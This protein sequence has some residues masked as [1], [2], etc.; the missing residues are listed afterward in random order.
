MKVEIKIPT[1]GESVSEA[2]VSQILKPSGS[3]VPQD[4]EILEIETDKVNQV[5]YAP[6]AGQL[7]LT[8]KVGD[9]VKIGQ[10]IGTIET[11]VAVPQ[12]APAPAPTVP[13]SGSSARKMAGDFLAELKNPPSPQA[14]PV[15]T[16][17]GRRRMSAL[18]RTIAQRLVEVKNQT[19]MLTTFNEVDMTAIMEIRAREKDRFQQKY[20]VKLGFMSFFVQA[21]VLALKEF[22]D[23][24]SYI[25][26]EDIVLF[27]NF[28]I[29]VA[30][31]TDKGLLVPVLRSCD[32][33]SHG[34]IE[35]QLESL[36][37][38]AREGT[39]AVD[40]LRGGS[41]TI[42]NG[43]VFGSLLST[44][45]LN[46]P[47]SAILG[48]HSIVKR[49]VALNDQIVIRPM[50]YLALSYDHRIIDGKEAVLFL[51]RLKQALESPSYAD[52]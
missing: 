48:M 49:P 51:G 24:H 20:G 13:T 2:T 38:K 1:L 47:Q 33:L 12:E 16:E 22:P 46:P 34:D 50:M 45:I 18:R 42:T 14:A 27:P 28:D 52:V 5:L 29:G 40:D 3:L 32:K 10:V 36:A 11:D 7:Q 39:I 17:P 43:G 8:V 4:A 21:C 31:S 37:K 15:P 41:F 35:K 23:V 25:D 26:G 30:V 19:A 9:K 6:K 44:P